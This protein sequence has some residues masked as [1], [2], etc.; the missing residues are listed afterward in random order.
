MYI[1]DEEIEPAVRMIGKLMYESKELKR[2]GI[3]LDEVQVEAPD[4]DIDMATVV[5]SL[6]IPKSYAPHVLRRVRDV[7]REAGQELVRTG[8]VVASKK[9]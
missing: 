7:L 2:L 5:W 1:G 4:G 6:H 8:L 9:S 3:I